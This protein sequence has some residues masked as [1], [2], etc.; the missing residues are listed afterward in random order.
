MGIGKYMPHLNQTLPSGNN[1]Y[2]LETTTELGSLLYPQT[3][4]AK[5]LKGVEFFG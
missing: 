3:M 1:N 4:I 5:L 2:L